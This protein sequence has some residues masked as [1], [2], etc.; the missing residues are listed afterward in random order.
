VLT[1]GHLAG[2]ANGIAVSEVV[3][4]SRQA[5][6]GS[7]FYAFRGEHVDGHAYVAAALQ[8][9][10]IAAFVEQPVPDVRTILPEQVA[11]L[12]AS[13]LPVAVQAPSTQVAL[14]QA[15]ARYRATLK[16]EVV[17]VTGSVGK[18]TAKEAIAAGADYIVVGRPIRLATDP[19]A[20]M[21]RLL[22]EI[23]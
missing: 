17:G 10:A 6:A 7:V 14:Q 16:L 22:E 3:I 2:C 15:A 1:L 11:A 4:D 18:T 19:A 5:K 23:Q 8:R 13:D 12:T 9:G 21:D 20:A